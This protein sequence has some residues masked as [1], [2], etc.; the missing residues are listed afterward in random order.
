[1]RGGPALQGDVESRADVLV[2][3]SAVL[4]K[5]I[6]IAGP[7]KL[8][9]AVASSAPDTDL[10]ARLVDVF[11]DGRAYGIQEGAL[12]LRYRDGFA[13]PRLL[14]PGERYEVEVDMRSIAYAFA[15]G[16]RLRLHVT[17]SS[18]PR[19]E[20]NL[21]TGAANNAGETRSEVAENRVFHGGGVSFLELPVL[22]ESAAPL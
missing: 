20:R 3:T 1:L 17:S 19:L 10:V 2:Y 22:P 21:N 14:V 6:T 4:E 8:R 5:G 18:F 12:R 7:L 9:V 13:A 15:P 11:P 16:H